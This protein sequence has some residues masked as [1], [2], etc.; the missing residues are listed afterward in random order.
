[1]T[2]THRKVLLALS[3]VF[4]WVVFAPSA[5]AAEQEVVAYRLMA[6]KT[7][8]FDDAQRADNHVS[9]LR[10]LGCDVRTGD[11]GGHIDVT[12]RCPEWREISL[13]S[14]AKAHTWQGWL[15]ASGFETR[16]EH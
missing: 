8:H 1:M 15:N 13:D 11:H 6:W 4:S 2:N 10:R 16:H 9:T 12:Y 7:V 14:H 5:S 3:L